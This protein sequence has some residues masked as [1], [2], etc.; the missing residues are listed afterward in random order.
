MA[1]I[2]VNGKQPKLSSL[3]DIFPNSTFRN[4]PYGVG[5]QSWESWEFDTNSLEL[6]FNPIYGETIDKYEQFDVVA[7]GDITIT[8]VVHRVVGGYDY[9][10]FCFVPHNMSTPELIIRTLC[11]SHWFGRNESL[12]LYEALQPHQ[13]PYLR[14][15]RDVRSYYSKTTEVDFISI[16]KEILDSTPNMTPDFREI[17]S[18][19]WGLE[20]IDLDDGTFPREMVEAQRE[21]SKKRQIADF[22]EIIESS[23]S[24][25]EAIYRLYSRGVIKRMEEYGSF[26]TNGSLNLDWVHSFESTDPHLNIVKELQELAELKE[27]GL[28]DEE[29]FKSAKNKLLK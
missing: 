12:E 4:P 6:T 21:E 26:R 3:E 23:S 18:R 13:D 9:L 22:M 14:T 27:K 15:A 17:M 1:I 2:K 24:H 29:E 10:L 5:Y 16:A 28:I 25:R 19:V 8:D 7:L 11:Y 20:P